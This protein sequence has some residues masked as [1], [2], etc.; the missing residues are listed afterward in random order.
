[1]IK[2]RGDADVAR[3]LFSLV[4]FG[5][6]ALTVWPL[7]STRYLPIEDLP[8][9]LAAIRVLHSYHDARFDFARYFELDLFGTQYLAYYLL[10]DGLAYLVDLEL[11]NR[12]IVVACA[13]ATPYALRYLL[14]AL[15]RPEW[16]ALF[17]LPLTYNA[18]LILGFINFLL[19]IPLALFGLGLAVRQ[20]SAPKVARG[21]GLALVA[22]LAFF[23]HVVPFALFALGC[24][25]VA[26]D[27]QPRRVLLRLLPLVPAGLASL[28]W[29]WRSPAGR[30]TLTAAVGGEAGPQP[31]Y[32]PAA[33][34][35]RDMPNWLTDT[36]HGAEAGS[37]LRGTALVFALTL[38]IGLGW[39]CWRR[40]REPAA[41][42]P[43]RARPAR[44]L[45]WRLLP[46]APLALLLYFVTPSAYAWIWPIAQR[47][48]LLAVLFAIPVLPAPPRAAAVL[49]A[50]A[51][52][53]LSFAE[54]RL[55]TRAFAA[56]DQ[57]E[58]G[59]FDAALAAIPPRKRVMGLIFARGSAQVKFSPF[60]HFVAYYQARKGGA[61]MF[62]FADFPQSPFRFRES[63]RP[64]R[65]PPRWE[66]LPQL[67]RPTDLA[68]YEYVLVRAGPSPCAHECKLVYRGQR[69]S[70]WQR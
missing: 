2:A 48:P 17:A 6:V 26:L 29:L 36:F 16:L 21:V 67:V 44:A 46:L 9:H 65:V 1:M 12:L 40:P 7:C 31:Q 25:L 43:D 54:Q 69:W 57:Q 33:F 56:F 14:R 32:Q 39:A 20:Y 41:G 37:L 13:M 64:P 27:R 47:F 50:G 15:D 22:L 59:D 66:W 61:V 55:V 34:A 18:H 10:A 30:A 53:A 60:I 24:L 63:D 23:S 3:R 45:V 4:F 52:L 51:L 49:L 19:A 5:A 68:W 38:L 58:V 8:Q 28:L 42:A 62:T 35:L 11:G 70:V